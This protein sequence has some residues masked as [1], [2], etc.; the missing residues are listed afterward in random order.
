MKQMS[1]FIVTSFLVAVFA[2]TS[3]QATLIEFTDRTAWETAIAPLSGGEDFN[4]FLVDTEFRSAPVALNMMSVS[5]SATPTNGANSN[6]IDVPPALFDG[7]ADVNGTAFA[8]FD[9]ETTNQGR[10]DFDSL[11]TAWGADFAQF[12]NDGGTRISQIE[13]YDSAELLGTITP[14]AG[15]GMEFY[16]FALTGG[17]TAS[18]LIF[19]NPGTANDYFGVDNIGFVEA[20]DVPAP[21]TLALFGLGL[22]GLGWSRRNKA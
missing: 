7:F 10:F 14:T 8:A 6:L 22:A 5:G 11:F 2:T 3:A 17:D 9:I 15:I 1:H 16:G 4:S 20:A 21:A 13:I 18:H 12:E 19:N